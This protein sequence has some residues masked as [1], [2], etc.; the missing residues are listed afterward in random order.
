M[1]SML[2]RSTSGRLVIATT[3]D[4]GDCNS[5]GVEREVPYLCGACGVLSREPGRLDHFAR[6]G[7]PRTFT[8]DRQQLE[9]AHM[10]LSKLLHPDLRVREGSAVQAKALVL[11]ARLNEAY[12]V[13]SDDIARAEHLLA[14]AG[15]PSADDDKTTPPGFLLEQL[16]LREAAEEAEGDAEALRALLSKV[17]P[18]AEA[19]RARVAAMLTGS[20]FPTQDLCA[21]LRVELNALRYWNSLT[22]ELEEKLAA[23][24][25]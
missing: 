8:L 11:S 20:C 4:V 10:K 9:E 23:L 1:N 22:A 12:R 18:A 13:L 15:G 5:C 21:D 6:L 7:L 17:K 3:D 16:E 24:S 19:G 25:A 14:L 2:E